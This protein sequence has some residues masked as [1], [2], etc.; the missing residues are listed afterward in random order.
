[1]RVQ[2]LPLAVRPGLSF[3][4]FL[5]QVFSSLKWIIK[6]VPTYW[7][8]KRLNELKYASYLGQCLTK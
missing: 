5:S 7:A 6:I 2:T 4:T 1:M 8:F 3:L